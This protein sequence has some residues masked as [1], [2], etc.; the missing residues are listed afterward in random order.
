MRCPPR[1]CC[2]TAKSCAETSPLDCPAIPPPT[3]PENAPWP[4]FPNFCSNDDPALISV[5][6]RRRGFWEE[7]CRR[8]IVF[9]T[10]VVAATTFCPPR[11]VLK[12]IEEKLPD[13]AHVENNNVIEL[14]ISFC[15]FVFACVKRERDV[16]GKDSPTNSSCGGL[17][18]EILSKTRIS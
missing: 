6:E 8:L 5:F 16:D 12:L 13:E 10:V 15:V 14:L 1:R 9:F 2:K 17:G 11:D 4:F 3:P 7:T 18:K